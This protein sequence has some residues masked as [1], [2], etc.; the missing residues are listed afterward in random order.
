MSSTMAYNISYNASGVLGSVAGG[1]VG[2]V[3]GFVVGGAAGLFGG[4]SGGLSSAAGVA[5][6]ALIGGLSA[7]ASY[8]ITQIIPGTLG[9]ILGV[10]GGIVVGIGLNAAAKGVNFYL[11]NEDFGVT[12]GDAVD[13]T[14]DVAK[15]GYIAELQAIKDM[16]VGLYKEIM[17]IP[18]LIT[19]ITTNTYTYADGTT[20]KNTGSEI[21]TT[22]PNHTIVH[23][24]YITKETYATYADG[25]IVYIRNGFAVT[26]NG[27]NITTYNSDNQVIYKST[28][29]GQTQVNLA[30]GQ[31]AVSPSDSSDIV[32]ST[33]TTGQV[34]TDTNGTPWTCQNEQ[35]TIW[36]NSQGNIA[37]YNQGDGSYILTDSSNKLIGVGSP[38][39]LKIVTANGV[40]QQIPTNATIIGPSDSQYMDFTDYDPT[41]TTPK[42][43]SQTLQEA[44]TYSP[45]QTTTTG[46]SGTA[47]PNTTTS[48]KQVSATFGKSL[49]VINTVGKSLPDA[50]TVLSS[51]KPIVPYVYNGQIIDLNSLSSA[52]GLTVPQIY[53]QPP[54]GTPIII[55]QRPNGV[56]Y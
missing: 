40:P 2:A 51:F 38:N 41:N 26:V 46:S 32:Q 31:N 56:I 5:A 11:N 13:Y 17:D 34:R 25:T 6:A 12:F 14:L 22:L 35:G 10:V 21:V 27:M 15:A 36:K 49:P 50:H 44:E 18:N 28:D 20:V 48:N 30:T 7:L 39:P 55:N 53:Q 29:G 45:G 3:L 16:I 42:T 9:Q 43:F 8:Y 19:S 52:A 1:I 23:D 54:P 33:N 4:I 47:T 24:N 37:I